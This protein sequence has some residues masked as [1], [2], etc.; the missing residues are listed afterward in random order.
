M[1]NDNWDFSAYE[2]DFSKLDKNAE[3]QIAD[4]HFEFDLPTAQL[5]ESEKPKEDIPI[6]P[7]PAVVGTVDT[8]VQK[9]EFVAT[10]QM[11]EQSQTVRKRPAPLKKEPS[12]KNEEIAEFIKKLEEL[13]DMVNVWVGQLEEI[14]DNK[15]EQLPKGIRVSIYRLHEVTGVF[16]ALKIILETISEEETPEVLLALEDNKVPS[17]CNRTVSNFE[18]HDRRMAEMTKDLK[19]AFETEDPEV[20]TLAREIKQKVLSIHSDSETLAEALTQFILAYPDKHA[21][22]SLFSRI[23][24]TGD[25]EKM[26]LI[27][28]AVMVTDQFA[29]PVADAPAMIKAL[30][31][32]DNDAMT[33]ILSRMIDKRSSVQITNK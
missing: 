33:G 5:R 28:R 9:K 19:V 21:E 1:A 14:R 3:K 17:C 10:P 7:E 4:D 29:V 12:I 16:K 23:A 15:K 32:K 25:E 2:M 11:D 31:E 18:R 22:L 24:A 20:R 26:E 13:T 6:E 27:D 8:Q 30:E